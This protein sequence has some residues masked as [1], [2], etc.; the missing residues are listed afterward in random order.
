MVDYDVTQ[1]IDVMDFSFIPIWIRVLKLPLDMMNKAIDE[2]IGGETGVFMAMN[3]KDD[4][5]MVGPLLRIK[6]G[7]AQHFSKK[8]R[9]SI[10]E[11]KRFD[12]G[13]GGHFGVT[14]LFQAGGALEEVAGVVS[15]DLGGIKVGEEE[16]VTSPIKT[17][18]PNELENAMS[19]RALFADRSLEK[20][21]LSLLEGAGGVGALVDSTEVRLGAKEG[22][23]VSAGEIG[24]HMN[25]ALQ[26]M[27]VDD[28]SLVRG[29][30]GE[31]EIG[32]KEKK[33]QKGG[34]YKKRPRQADLRGNASPISLT[35]KKRVL[36]E[37]MEGV[38]GK[39]QKV[40]TLSYEVGLSDQPCEDQ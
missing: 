2:A 4:D 5:T 12:E 29:T 24:G 11:K 10:T 34:R 23:G 16:E 17:K 18:K 28:A 21:P 19:K 14:A 7:E 6:K 8:L 9:C 1:T 20:A 32:E 36:E 13:S 27:H 39:K 31:K 33:G 22:V 38:K 37:G 25:S 15:R 40:I 3:A 26:A 35:K 30:E